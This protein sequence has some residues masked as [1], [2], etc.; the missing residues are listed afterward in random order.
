MFNALIRALYRVAHWGLRL[1]W[2]IRR[3][4]TTGALVA[5]WHRGRVLL[6][7]NSYRA[8][9]TLPGGYIRPR[10]DRRTAA[11]RELR[12]EVGIN[13]Q[14]KRLVHAYHGTHVFEHR[15]DTLDIYELEME[16]EPNIDVD[17]REV[18]RAEFL[19]PEEALGMQI[20]PHL[21]E[22]LSKRIARA[23]D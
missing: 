6:V 7:K 12:E 15:Q 16:A 23:T 8:Q 9:L 13:V 5:V 14:P 11:A 3:P 20:V 19:I 18:V 22:Y 4:E 17:N 10:E 1:L 2:F 21:D